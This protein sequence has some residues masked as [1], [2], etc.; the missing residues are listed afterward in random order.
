MTRILITGSNSG[1]GELA[2]LTLA[3]QG[4]DVIATMR[5][6]AKGDDLRS[7]IEA[8]HL[9]IE[10]RR[11]DVS[12]PASVA[13]GVGD[14]TEID[15]IVNNAGFEVTGALELVDDDLWTRQLDTNVLGPMRVIRAVLPAWRARGSGTIVNVSSIAGVVGSP[16][17]G[18]YSASKHALEGLSEVLHFETSG[19]GIRV[20]LVEPGAF[21]T[22]FHA[23]IVT[24]D[25][26]QES[27]Y[28][29]RAARF[30]ESRSVLSGDGPAPDPQDVADAIVRAALDPDAPFRNFVGNDAQ[31]I[32]SVKSSMPFEE[33]EAV[34]RDTLDWH[35]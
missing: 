19:F 3:R 18:A 14:P 15:V 28:F 4:H 16:F 21:E 8:E 17:G 22:D 30:G 29:D 24:V 2:A 31:L 27:D 6:L 20:R 9:P 1:F 23:N 33:F 34:M 11:L 12:N 32:H 10:I 25:G 13:E 35:E 26:W 7:A 5:T